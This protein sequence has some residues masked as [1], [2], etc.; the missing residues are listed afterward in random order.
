MR[1]QVV[2]TTGMLIESVR[3]DRDFS[4][5][6][7]RDRQFV[8]VGLPVTNPA[9]YRVSRWSECRGIFGDDVVDSQIRAIGKSR[10]QVVI[11]SLRRPVAEQR[12]E[13]VLDHSILA[14]EIQEL[15]DLI[16]S[17][18]RSVRAAMQPV[19]PQSQLDAKVAPT[20]PLPAS[21]VA[22]DEL[23]NHTGFD[24]KVLGRISIG[25]IGKRAQP[26]I[27]T[28]GLY[29]RE[30][31]VLKSDVPTAEVR[32]AGRCPDVVDGKWS[33]EIQCSTPFTGAE[34]DTIVRADIPR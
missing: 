22:V 29:F 10:Y 27:R 5:G 16:Q 21:L 17:E 12:I 3:I 19:R 2:L 14:G 26:H 9:F 20:L 32:S 25:S 23:Q 6:G 18:I 31:C 13:S 4:A 15:A 24:G 30:N 8:G 7:K 11:R 34:A 33:A 28:F 1:G